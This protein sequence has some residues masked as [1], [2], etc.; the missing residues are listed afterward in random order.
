MGS[1]RG[2]KRNSYISYEDVS[3]PYQHESQTAWHQH[4]DNKWI[5]IIMWA[6]AGIPITGREDDI[7]FC[8]DLCDPYDRKSD[9]C[10]TWRNKVRERWVRRYMSRLDDEKSLGIWSVYFRYTEK[11]VGKGLKSINFGDFMFGWE[12]LKDLALF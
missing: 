7:D 5:L 8:I 2:I 11:I 9:S 12:K 1:L 6:G 4:W 10:W 3:I